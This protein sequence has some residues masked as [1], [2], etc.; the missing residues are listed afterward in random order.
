LT[1]YLTLICLNWRGEKLHHF[2][3]YI[4]F[5]R[6]A[7]YLYTISIVWQK[8]KWVLDHRQTCRLDSDQRADCKTP[9]GTWSSIEIA[10]PVYTRIHMY[11]TMVL[12]KK[13]QRRNIF[14]NV[15]R[16]ETFLRKVVGIGIA[17]WLR[18]KTVVNTL[19]T[20]LFL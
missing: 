15:S 13:R 2:S 8:S 5:T 11:Y 3:K 10:S 1:R 9:V 19:E 12:G 7:R 4:D 14:N 20:S 17:L 6:N 16:Y 18:Q